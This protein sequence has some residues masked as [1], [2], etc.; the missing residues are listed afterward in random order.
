MSVQSTAGTCGLL[1]VEA[2]PDNRDRARGFES[3]PKN[4]IPMPIHIRLVPSYKTCTEGVTNNK[5]LASKTFVV[6]GG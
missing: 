3:Y 5:H 6:W 1:M 4:L 2:S